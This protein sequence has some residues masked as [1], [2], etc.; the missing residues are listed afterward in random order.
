M[1]E[2]VLYKMDVRGWG[3]G[4]LFYILFFL[5]FCLFFYFIL[6]LYIDKVLIVCIVIKYV[7]IYS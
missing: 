7:L 4:Y 6:C 1:Y 5:R 2:V 3:L